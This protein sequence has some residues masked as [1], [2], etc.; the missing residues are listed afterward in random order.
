MLSQVQDE[1]ER[2]L[3]CWGR[4]CNK[5][6]KDYPSY[7][8]EVLVVIQCKHIL[9]Y[10]LFEVHTDASALKYLTNMKYQS[11]LYTR[12][13]QELAGFNFTV[14]HKIGKE[15]SNADPLRRSS[16]IFFNT[17]IFQNH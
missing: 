12:W 14:N 8:G 10:R 5:Y 15:N 6:E 7:I 17:F 16:H 2:F 4:K 1:R 3:G 13:D 11:G 9:S